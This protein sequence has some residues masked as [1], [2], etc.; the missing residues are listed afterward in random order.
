[1]NRVA[2]KRMPLPRTGLSRAANIVHGVIFFAF[3][4]QAGIS[5]FNQVPNLALFGEARWP[6]GLLL[7]LC[8]AT[9]VASLTRYLPSQNVMLATITVG[10][11]A[12]GLEVLNAFT[13]VPFGPRTF[14][15]R[16]GQHLFYPLPW[17]MPVL[18]LVAILNTRGVARL[19]LRPWRNGRN[20]GLGVIGTAVALMV[21]FGLC[22]D[23]VATQVKSFWVWTPNKS[24]LNW[25]HAPAITFVS[26]SVVSLL[27]LAFATPALINKQPSPSRP[28]RDALWVWLVM[29]IWVGASAATQHLWA[30]IG[31]SGACGVVVAVFA[32]RGART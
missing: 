9:T 16:M 11:L 23:P 22:L 19:I 27:L 3:L 24:A 10:V 26:W 6:D 30:V 1:M 15:P 12:G 13:G 21:V 2:F 29:L 4:A 20:Y 25:Y 7:F 18:W 32:L 17:A 28:H 5:I 14:T 31:L 8:A